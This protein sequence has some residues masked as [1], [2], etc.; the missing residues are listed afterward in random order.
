MHYFVTRF[1]TD[2][3]ILIFQIIHCQQQLWTIICSIWSFCKSASFFT[4][5]PTLRIIWWRWNNKHTMFN[6]IS[7]GY[8]HRIIRIMNSRDSRGKTLNV[9]NFYTAGIW[10]CH[11][12]R[13]NIIN[14]SIPIRCASLSPGHWGRAAP[15]QDFIQED[16]PILVI[17]E[18]LIVCI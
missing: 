12:S 5:H 11:G 13:S 16:K 9:Y 17:S 18:R 4:L 6:G 1:L 14:V 2:K 7:G 10:T 3:S 8:Y 15:W